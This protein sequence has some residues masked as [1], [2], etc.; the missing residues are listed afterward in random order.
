[1][2][3]SQ[4]TAIIVLLAGLGGVIVSASSTFGQEIVYGLAD[5]AACRDAS[6]KLEEPRELVKPKAQAE[7]APF[8]MV[9]I[10]EKVHG[11]D[12]YFYRA[13]VSLQPPD[14]TDTSCSDGSVGQPKS[15]IAGTRRAP[16]CAQ[17][18]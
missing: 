5:G 3:E 11:K 9:R 13:E 16:N 6:G 15:S 4:R 10:K 12:C 18:Q 17:K 2:K 8:G 1:M 14:Q 7:K